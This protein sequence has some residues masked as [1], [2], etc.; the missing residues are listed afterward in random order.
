M[1]DKNIKI[2]DDMGFADFLAAQG[3]DPS[4]LTALQGTKAEDKSV[5]DDSTNPVQSTDIKAL[6]QQALGSVGGKGMDDDVP[7]AIDGE[8]PAALSQGEYV[9]PADVVALLGDGNSK[10][11]AKVLDELATMIRQMKQGN[12]EQAAKLEDLLQ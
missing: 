3:I 9:I 8:T 6:L 7:A 10:A 5:K 11:G 1:A 4:T 12:P 2:K